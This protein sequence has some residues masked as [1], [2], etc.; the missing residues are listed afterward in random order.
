MQTKML[1]SKY[2]YLSVSEF[3]QHIEEEVSSAD[4]IN[5]SYNFSDGLAVGDV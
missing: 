5:E 1:T 3:V 2:G 4:C